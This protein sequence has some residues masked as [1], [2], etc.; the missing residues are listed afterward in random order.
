MKRI[1]LLLL[2]IPLVSAI[3]VNSGENL[4]INL[5][6]PFA[7]YSVVGNSSEVN[8]NVVQNGNQVKIEV[9]KYSPSDNFEIIFFDVQNNVIYSSSGSSGGTTTKYVDKIKYVDKPIET[10]KYLTNETQ[11][12]S[13]PI[14]KNKIPVWVYI[15]IGILILIAV[16]LFVVLGVL[17]KRDT[18][19]IIEFSE[20]R[21]EENE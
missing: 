11:I 17:L 18:E 2:L 8:L 15:V 1:I 5:E 9:N 10:V 21:Y 4:T 16:T 6:K 12:P 20:R 19:D 3:Q 13:E 14:I 7:Y